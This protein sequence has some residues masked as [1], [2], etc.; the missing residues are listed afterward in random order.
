MTRNLPNLPLRLAGALLAGLLLTAAA[1]PAAPDRLPGE[2][3]GVV[4]SGDQLALRLM[5]DRQERTLKLGDEY[6]DGWRLE[7]LT[8]TSATLAREGQRR[9]VG[10]NPTGQLAGSAPATPPSQVRVLLSDEEILAMVRS[11]PPINGGKPMVGMTAAESERYQVLMYKGGQLRAASRPPS[12]APPPDGGLIR[13]QITPSTELIPALGPEGPELASLLDKMSLGYYN[14]A[15]TAYQ[16]YGPIEIPRTGDSSV[17]NPR[18]ADY[19][20]ARWSSRGDSYV[21]IMPA[22]APTLISAPAP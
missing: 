19:P 17:D 10:L 21:M 14:D 9:E 18:M 11:R 5:Q 1:E 4:G 3:V 12:P 6:R 15:V 20:G 22:T 2:A 8:P 13:V 7:A 16:R